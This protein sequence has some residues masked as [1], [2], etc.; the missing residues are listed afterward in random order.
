MRNG[1]VLTDRSF[2]LSISILVIW[3]SSSG[4]FI[5]SAAWST[6]SSYGSR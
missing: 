5:E 4:V 1:V 3:I 2:T 6:S